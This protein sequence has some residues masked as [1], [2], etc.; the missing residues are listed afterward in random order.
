[1]DV[2]VRKQ[3]LCRQCG[4]SG[5][6]TPQDVKRCDHC[7]GSGTRVVRQQIAPGFVQ[8]MQTP[9]DN[10]KGKGKIVTRKCRACKGERV[11]SGRD[12]VT[13]DVERGVSDGHTIKIERGGDESPDYTSGN[14][15]FKITTHPHPVFR[16]NQRNLHTTVSRRPPSSRRDMV[17]MLHRT[18]GCVNLITDKASSHPL[19]LD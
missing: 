19:T 15:N 16:R 14:L 11:Q 9:C 3:I 12:T 7:G 5:A 4:G 18:S 10:C 8:Q 17:D 2:M 6:H 1:M 13:L